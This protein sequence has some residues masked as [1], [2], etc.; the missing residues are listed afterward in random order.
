MSFT[1][2]SATTAPNRPI[3]PLCWSLLAAASLTTTSRLE[4]SIARHHAA[5]ARR[6]CAFD[7]VVNQTGNPDRPPAAADT[8][9]RGLSFEEANQSISCLLARNGMTPDRRGLTADGSALFQFLNRS[10]AC[11]DLYPS[12][13]M[14]VVIR[15]S[16]ID[17]IHEL[18]FEDAFRMIELLKDAGV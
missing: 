7:E 10:K 6:I 15:K 12:G 3:R 4:D 1:A 2:S 18:R 9:R 13:E 16:D 11:I 14:A 17:E 5:F 8:T